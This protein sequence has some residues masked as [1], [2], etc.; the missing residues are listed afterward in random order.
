MYHQEEAET[1]RRTLRQ[2]LADHECAEVISQR[3]Y[4]WGCD[5][6]QNWGSPWS[7]VV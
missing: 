7:R 5:L 6:S 3:G 4:P 2:H 1:L